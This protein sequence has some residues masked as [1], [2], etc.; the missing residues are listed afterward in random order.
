MEMKEDLVMYNDYR[1]TYI[2]RVNG[3]WYAFEGDPLRGQ[4]LSIGSDDPENGR[5]MA[6]W[7]ESG[8]KYVASPSPSRKAAYAKARRHGSYHGERDCW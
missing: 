6:R 4:V 1:K 7:T 2:A 8:I 3:S 5:W